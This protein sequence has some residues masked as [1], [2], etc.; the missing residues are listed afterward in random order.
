MLEVLRKAAAGTVAKVLMGLLVLSFAIWGIGD[1]FR[2]FGSRDLAKIG[3]TTIGI[4]QFR[5]L[6]QERLQQ[7]SRQLGRGLSPDQAR[8]L[9]IDR[10]LLGE[11]M[12]EAA[13]DEK[14][15]QLGLGVGNETL[16]EHIHADSAF[17]GPNGQFDPARFYETL[18]SAG[19][20]EA[21][22][23][24]GERRL[25]LRQ[26]LARA[27][28]G[29]LK[30]PDTLVEA[31][32]RFE[33]EER[34]VEFAVLGREQAGQIPAPSPAEI[35]AYFNE[36]KASFRA[37]EYRKL[38]LLPLTP[39]SLAAEMQIP[40][41]DLRKAYDDAKDRFATPERREVDQI[42]FSTVD[43][44]AAA[45]KRIAEGAKFEDIAAERKLKP[46]DVS[47]GVVAKRDILDPKIADAIFALTEGKV[48]DPIQGRFGSVIARVQKIVPGKEPAFDEIKDELRKDLAGRRARGLILDRH[49]KIEDERAG[50]LRLAE[51]G[52]KLGMKTVTIDAVDRSGRGPDGKPV[53]G[54]PS[55]NQVITE[56][57]NTEV[58]IESDP[59]E[60]GSGSYVWYEVVAITPSRD[61][62][63]DEARER[64]QT[65]W[66]DE[67]IT[68]RLAERA[69]AL[70]TRLDAGDSFAAAAP[71]LKPQTREKLRRAQNVD[72]LDRAALA[73]I[74]QTPQGKAGIAPAADGVGRVVFRV[75]AVDVPAGAAASQRVAQLNTGLQDDLL[76]EYVLHLQGALGVRV[77]EAAL[78]TVTGAAPRN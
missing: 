43:E 10:E 34:S 27:L 72:G 54:V 36:R 50:G 53:E 58:G 9:G 42:L 30:A 66:Y 73:A 33:S 5:Q 14:T 13:L 75:T 11:L 3:S 60:I 24:D 67:Q 31:V 35:E 37:P 21:R 68:K 65:A 48:S 52:A 19:F 40:D 25:M 39:E 44:A 8:S 29:D 74:F 28:G 61:R 4:E 59:V 26:Q 7:L 69:E 45:A 32:R 41:A 16:L 63:L 56:A 57:F 49:D 15:R 17:K 18:R 70:R 46:T 55:L 62:T 64:V 2:G 51:V 78:Q 76:V 47:L 1:V 6:Y 12:S 23:I 38:V 22:F 71:E 77:N 20:T